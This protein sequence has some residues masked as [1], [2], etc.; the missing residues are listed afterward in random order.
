MTTDSERAK[1]TRPAERINAAIGIASYPLGAVV[2]LLTMDVNL[3]GAVLKN[4]YKR[5][6]L[7]EGDIIKAPT[8]SKARSIRDFQQIVYDTLKEK[9]EAGETLNSDA[10]KD[11]MHRFETTHELK[12]TGEAVKFGEKLEIAAEESG[13]VK[14]KLTSLLIE[15]ESAADKIRRHNKAYSEEVRTFFKDV[16]ISKKADYWAAINR[17]QKV[18]ALV[19]GFTFAAVTIGSMLAISDNRSAVEKLIHGDKKDP[20]ASPSR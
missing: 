5:G 1:R 14:G 17:N 19:I 10:A 11:F 16:G 8:S 9:I 15:K 2:G 7:V 20:D 6:F 13:K 12:H 18:E 3:R 4:F